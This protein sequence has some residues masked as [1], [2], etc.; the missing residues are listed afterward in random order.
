MTKRSVVITT[1][2]LVG[3]VA[4]FTILFGMV[5][6]VRDIQVVHGKDFYH[7][8]EIN[9]IIKDSKLRKNIGI[10]SVDT[11]KISANIE[12][13]YPN[14]R[15]DSVNI[16]SFTSVK[17]KLSNREPLYYVVE[18]AVYYILD[19]D[20]K[21]LEVTNNN[22][23]ASGYIKLNNMFNLG[24]S[25][26]A[27]DFLGGKY[28][29]LCNS[30]YKSIYSCAMLN[31]DNGSG[32]YED[33]YL[34]REDMCQVINDI[35]LTQVNEL[36]GKVDKIVLSTSFG[37]KIS[38]IDPQQDLDLKINMAFSA[39]RT[40]IA[41]D[42]EDGTNLST[43]GTIAVRYSYDDNNNATLKCEYHI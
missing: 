20:C 18:E 11:D 29:K 16:A 27:G 43:T 6:R 42:A 41:Q 37:S 4:I 34:E 17:I 22:L 9:Q 25:V 38:I 24:S 8:T 13:E 12:K 35:S 26:Q 28:A 21:V 19:E 23:R 3:I 36:K 2:I 5:F 30:L 1:S 15:V 32:E 33:R 40:I 7:K 10:F 31:L 39:L 14:I